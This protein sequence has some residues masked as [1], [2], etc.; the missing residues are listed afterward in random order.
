MDTLDYS[1]RKDLK[2]ALLIINP[3]SGKRMVLRN[4]RL[5]RDGVYL[6]IAPAPVYRR[7]LL[8][9]LRQYPL[10]RLRLCGGVHG[11]NGHTVQLRHLRHTQAAKP[12]PREQLIHR[13]AYVGKSEHTHCSDLLFIHV[14]F[15]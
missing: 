6:C 3:V 8:G 13:I 10:R 4:V 14:R 5:L 12:R 9:E 15:E 1:E 11:R 2:P 7:L